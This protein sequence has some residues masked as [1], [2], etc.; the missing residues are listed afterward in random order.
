MT[1]PTI[2]RTPRVPWITALFQPRAIMRSIQ[3]GELEYSAL[4]MA[5]LT[6]MAQGVI[7]FVTPV[8]NVRDLLIRILLAVL[9]GGSLGV[10][11]LG[12]GGYL[13]QRVGSRLGGRAALEDVYGAM[14]WSAIPIQLLG[15]LWFPLLWAFGLN[16]EVIGQYGGAL[17][18]AILLGGLRGLVQL[19]VF[20]LFLAAYAEVQGFSI[21]R[22]FGAIILTGVVAL[23][24]A[25]MAA[26]GVLFVIRFV[27]NSS[28][29]R[30]A[31]LLTSGFVVATIFSLFMA[32]RAQSKSEY[33][34]V[35]A[36]I[37]DWSPERVPDMYSVEV[38]APAHQR[39]L[40]PLWERIKN[41][42]IRLTP[43]EKIEGLRKD[44][45]MAG[46]PG[47]LTVTDI[48]GI[49]FLAGAVLS[50][51]A[52][53]IFTPRQPLPIALLL[54]FL[55]FFMG[56]YLPTYWLRGRIRERQKAINRALPDALDMLHICVDAG[57]G[58]DAA[59]Q[60]V[61]YKWDNPLAIELR[62]VVSEIRVGVDRAEALRH[63]AERTG[64]PDVA[65]F[66]GVIIQ[67]ERLGVPIS[68]VL[69]TQADQMR[70]RR[71]QRAEEE[72][73]KA[74]VKMLLPLALFILPAT[75]LTILGPAIPRFARL[76][77]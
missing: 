63:L 9:I 57:L 6:G 20:V 37:S 31:I 75:F 28:S 11:W 65:T 32:L 76:F 47:G 52:M 68:K 54:T 2:T 59:V 5:I 66:V 4:M 3:S 46:Y 29:S 73:R 61:A 23:F 22:A 14:V 50:A 15:L 49:R 25:G 21:A 27:L 19:W 35:V 24:G 51:G 7:L 40:N 74:P 77:G 41:I 26:L 10:A 70:T 45:I 56:L 67:S 55:S 33:E 64:V 34:E 48:L 44:L 69:A 18:P 16:A 39:L 43:K 1:T 53:V 17:L 42:G 60:R 58:F 62:R 71:R 8:A 12:V 13:L 38:A 72:A 30:G 36:A